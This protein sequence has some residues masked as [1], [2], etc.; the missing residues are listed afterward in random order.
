M[1]FSYTQNKAR[2]HGAGTLVFGTFTN[3]AT[4]ET[5][6]VGGDIATGATACVQTFAIG[7]TGT[8]VE[9][10]ASAVNEAFPS[11]RAVSIINGTGDD[12]VYM[13]L[14]R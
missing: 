8:A 10:T 2:I 9:A 3:N 6:D 12:G 4:H 7:L 13:G 14:V 1:T 11:P 5:N